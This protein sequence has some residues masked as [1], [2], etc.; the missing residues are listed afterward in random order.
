[1]QGG[2]TGSGE[3]GGLYDQS[4]HNQPSA[5]FSGIGMQQHTSHHNPS[6]PMSDMPS[7]MSIPIDN[8]TRRLS[9]NERFE[10]LKR[11][12]ESNGHCDV[13]QIYDT[14]LGTWVSAQRSQFKRYVVG[15]TSSMTH[16]RKAALDKLGFSWSLRKRFSWEERFSELKHFS[17]T[18]GGSCDVPNEGDYKPLW[19]WCQNQKQAY[20]RGKEG[21]S[22]PVPMERI[23]LMEQ[24]GFKWTTGSAEYIPSTASFPSLSTPTEASSSPPMSDGESI[25][26]DIEIGEL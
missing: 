24:I 15:K 22:H 18:H 2:A 26:S 25:C 11:Y 8:S 3:S 1:M 12:K 5:A 16:Q 6:I 4:N 13:P 19:T 21:K 23:T 20:K 9:W 17:Q 10:E 14:G 7:S